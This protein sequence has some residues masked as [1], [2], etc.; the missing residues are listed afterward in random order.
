MYL[1]LTE[2]KLL[3]YTP[4]TACNNLCIVQRILII[5]DYSIHPHFNASQNIK[6]SARIEPL[7]MLWL[8]GWICYAVSW[9]CSEIYMWKQR[10][11]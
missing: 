2:V 9:K 8:L 1:W 10:I 6:L 3:N 4:D 7:T 5:S 11:L